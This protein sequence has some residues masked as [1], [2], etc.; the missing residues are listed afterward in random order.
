MND[1]ALIAITLLLLAAAAAAVWLLRGSRTPGAQVLC[2][3]GPAQG[4]RA[5]FRDGRIRIGRATDNDIVLSE[6]LVSPHH[7]EIT[8]RS[9]VVMIEDL[10]SVNGTWVNGQRVA[11]I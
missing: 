10:D 4:Q 8:R 11:Q 6:P 9:D 7:A 5:P 2:V 1:L 3:A